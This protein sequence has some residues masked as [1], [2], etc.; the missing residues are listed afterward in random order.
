MVNPQWGNFQTPE[1]SNMIFNDKKKLSQEAA[2]NILD[3]KKPEPQKPQWGNF[4]TPQTYQ[5]KVD[6]NAEEGTL[7]YLARNL[8]GLSSRIGEQFAGRAGNLEK[9]SKDV[10][11]SFPESGG[12]LGSAINKLIG[13]EKWEKLIRG[14]T[15]QQMFPTSQQLRGATKELTGGFTEPKSEG[16]EKV[17]EY[18]EDVGSMLG[19]R[20]SPNLTGQTFQQR[21]LRESY[22][23]LL[24]PAAANVAKQIALET[25]FGEDK[26]N[27]AKLAAWMPLS[28]VANVNAPQYASNLMNMARNQLPD[29]LQANVPRL[30]Q[31][32]DRISNSPFFSQADPRTALARQILD[33]VRRDI[34]NGQTSIRSLL[35]QFDGVNAA[36]RNRGLFELG[37][38]G[39]QRFARRAIDEVKNVVRD[40]I[41]D[42]GSAYPQALENWRNGVQAW[43]VIHRSNAIENYVQQVAKGPY[44]KILS[45][46]A[47]GLFGV[48]SAALYKAPLV[49]GTGAGVLSSL[50]KTGKTMYRMIQD[51]NLYRYYWNSIN[52]ALEE[53]LP[54]F[55]S[56]YNKLNKKL[57]TSDSD[58]PKSK[59]KKK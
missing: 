59:E 13:P 26:A 8:L 15:G 50:Y 53:N 38:A 21:A 52:A 55:I 19:G 7:G 27:L 10:L 54:T 45:G 44:A 1:Q 57:E 5:G 40:E 43:S 22:N 14:P 51:P 42:V 2:G 24:I 28:L 56:N 49:S 41:M 4:Q 47:L 3:Q 36:K 20:R 35:T 25:G 34:A 32:L 23:K 16:E 48:S 12:I 18:F 30:L 46:P 58:N 9:F 37:S 29:S 31:R 17:H 39:D 6:E 11:V 33:G